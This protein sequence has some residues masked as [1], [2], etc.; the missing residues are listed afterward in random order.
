MSRDTGFI[1]DYDDN[2]KE[3]ERWFSIKSECKYRRYAK[4]LESNGIATTWSKVKDLYRYDKRLAFNLF[5]YISFL[6]E[7]L[8]AR[9]VESEGNT[10]E[11]YDQWQCRYLKDLQDPA[12]RI[13][14]GGDDSEVRCMNADF[15]LVKPLRNT[16]MHAKIIIGRHDFREA[17]L[18]L[19]DLLPIQYKDGFRKDISGCSRGLDVDGMWLVHFHC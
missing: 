14:C 13:I 6:E 1:T 5:K 18:A 16:V 11:S 10:E 8:R 2:R 4:I 12:C 15:E 3:I 7:Y 19:E 17:I 9:I